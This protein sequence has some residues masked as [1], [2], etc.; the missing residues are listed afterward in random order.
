METTRCAVGSSTK[1][2]TGMQLCKHDFNAGKTRSWL[3]VNRDSPAIVL[4]RNRT[5][6]MNKNANGLPESTV[7]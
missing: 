7:V 4:D 3:Y 5:V 2:P 1:L 6:G